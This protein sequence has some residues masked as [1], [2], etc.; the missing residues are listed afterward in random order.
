MSKRNTK[1]GK[2]ARRDA[3]IGRLREHGIL[4]PIA[5][6]QSAAP[7]QGVKN[8]YALRRNTPKS[9]RPVVMEVVDPKILHHRAKQN[10]FHVTY[11]GRS[12]LET[13]PGHAPRPRKGARR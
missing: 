7:R 9:E 1:E 2:K 11:G 12:E 4:L 8:K 13:L 3:R 5:G 10:R 6:E